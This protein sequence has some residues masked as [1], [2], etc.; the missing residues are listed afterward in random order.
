MN[1]ILGPWVGEF[2]WE[3][4]FSGLARKLSEK[5]QKTI[6][7]T[8]PGRE[9]LYMDFA[10]VITHRIKGVS[11]CVSIFNAD[12]K[13]TKDAH[14]EMMEI[15]R[16]RF[17]GNCVLIHPRDVFQNF[18]A[19]EDDV[20]KVGKY[21]V[22]DS[23]FNSPR[24]DLVVHARNRL[25]NG[26]NRNWGLK[27]WNDLCSR[28]SLQGYKMAAIGFSSHCPTGCEDYLGLEL[29]QTIG[30]M[31]KSRLVVGESSGPMHLASLCRVPH[32]VW[33]DS[34]NN[35]RRRYE[36]TWNFHNFEKVYFHDE[37]LHKPVVDFVY[38]RALEVLL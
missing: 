21:V 2:G 16:T 17:G 3:I 10:E 36:E 23:S 8:F 35:L 38:N 6:I 34:A 4:V 24:F 5:Y 22:L 13:T 1:L 9:A 32:L 12:S 26:V 37:Y 7:C 33:G 29:D 31:R 25:D 30:M 27:R 20:K 19:F 14:K 28:L 11:D 15:A 18:S